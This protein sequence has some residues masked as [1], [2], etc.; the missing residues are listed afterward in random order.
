MSPGHLPQRLTRESIAGQV[1]RPLTNCPIGLMRF[2]RKGRVPKARGRGHRYPS[3]VGFPLRASSWN[4]LLQANDGR[5]AELD[6]IK[7]RGVM[8]T[9]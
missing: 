5:V 1:F 9:R 3:A 2:H 4:C 6:G 8:V 7:A